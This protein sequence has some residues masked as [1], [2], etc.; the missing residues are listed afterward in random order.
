M[1][2]TPKSNQLSMWQG[3]FA[4]IG[5][6]ISIGVTWGVL[7][8]RVANL[9]EKNTYNQNKIEKILEDRVTKSEFSEVKQDIKDIKLLIERERDRER[10]RDKKR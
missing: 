8:N 9:E 6:F 3:A 10:E 4:L 5:V 2:T 1:P 7:S